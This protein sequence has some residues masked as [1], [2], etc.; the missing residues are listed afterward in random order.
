MAGFLGVF[1][2]FLVENGQKS[3]L[4]KQQLHTVIRFCEVDIFT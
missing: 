4:A 2:T 3:I 1:L